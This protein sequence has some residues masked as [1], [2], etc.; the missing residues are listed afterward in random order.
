MNFSRILLCNVTNVW[1]F[2]SEN[3]KREDR[4]ILRHQ[5]KSIQSFREDVYF[6]VYFSFPICFLFFFYNTL[7]NKKFERILRCHAL[8]SELF[9]IRNDYNLLLIIILHLFLYTSE[10]EFKRKKKMQNL[11]EISFEYQHNC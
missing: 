6:S 2:P 3:S 9:H 8:K 7:N 11:K 5:M 1:T 4:G 10:R